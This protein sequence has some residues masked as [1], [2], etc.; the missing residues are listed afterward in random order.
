MLEKFIWNNFGLQPLSLVGEEGMISLASIWWESGSR[1]WTEGG[2]GTEE[3]RE[4]REMGREEK[5]VKIID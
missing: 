5:R 1:H 4:G 3:G 2:G